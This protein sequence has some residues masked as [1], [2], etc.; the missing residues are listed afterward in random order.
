MPDISYPVVVAAAKTWFKLGAVDVRMEGVDLL[1][2][3]G[4]A[5]L[6]VNHTSYVDYLMA[7]YP[8]VARGRYTRFMAKREVFDHPVGGP[9]MRSFKHISVDR[10]AGLES[11]DV[12]A[13]ALRRGELV[14]IFPEATISRSFLIKELKT[15]AVRI[16]AKA[17]VPLFPVVTWGCQR[18]FTKDHPK[19]F[20]RGKTV[21]VKVGEPM[22]PTGEDPVAETAELKR[23]MEALL[24]ACIREYPAE[25]QPPGSW[26]LPASYGGSAPT[27]EEAEKI[28]ADEK[29]QRAARKREKAMKKRK[30]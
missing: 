30:K 13:E 5:M 8:S 20:K 26:W 11:M 19:D 4:G 15:G 10:S 22:Y 28:D 14:G 17:G 21:L 25:E 24:D 7:G 1:P 29:R 27:L 18:M 23:R 3:T 9:V 6:A 12:A 16:S 2:E